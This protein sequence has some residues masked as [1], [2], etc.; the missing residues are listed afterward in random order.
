MQPAGASRIVT[1]F[2]SRLRPDADQLG[3][4]EEAAR[5]ESRARAMPGFVDLKT[6]TAPDGER[7]SIITF[8]TREH[9]D[10]WRDD[11]EHVVAQRHGREKYYE[12]YSISVCEQLSHRGFRSA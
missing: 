11:P 7:V 2:R 12:E 9:Q 10:A 5:M 1:I 3:Y 4:G 8:E 6:F